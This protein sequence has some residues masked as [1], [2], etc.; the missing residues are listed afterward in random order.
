MNVSMSELVVKRSRAT[1]PLLAL[2][3][4][5]MVVAASGA[6]PASATAQ[7]PALEQYRGPTGPPAGHA[8][9]GHHGGR[10]DTGSPPSGSHV[11]LPVG[12][13]PVTPFVLALGAILGA[14]VL[15]RLGVAARR[16]VSVPTSARER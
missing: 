4:L 6:Q 2:A 16:A 11:D 14:G 1:T 13:Y 15:V 10:N 9:P 3:A 12:D 5:T 8:G 7:S